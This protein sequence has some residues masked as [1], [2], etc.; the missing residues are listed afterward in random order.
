MDNTDNVIIVLFTSGAVVPSL[1]CV[2]VLAAS[3]PPLQV[4]QVHFK[5]TNSPGRCASK[6]RIGA[7]QLKTTLCLFVEQIS[8]QK[9]RMN[10][11]TLPAAHQPLQSYN[12]ARSA[13]SKKKKKKNFLARKAGCVCLG[14]LI[15]VLKGRDSIYNNQISGREQ[16]GDN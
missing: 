8:P 15:V 7:F 3:H 6:T 1:C 10:T 16:R 9:Y 14:W 11:G 5:R 4:F 2:Q 13:K 12:S